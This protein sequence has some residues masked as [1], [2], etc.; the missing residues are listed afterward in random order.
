MSGPTVVD[1][2]AFEYRLTEVVC[3][4]R[5]NIEQHYDASKRGDDGL[6]TGFRARY[7]CLA[8]QGIPAALPSL[9]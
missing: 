8:V 1:T 7:A 6:V 9:H 4:I 2:A 3:R 5:C